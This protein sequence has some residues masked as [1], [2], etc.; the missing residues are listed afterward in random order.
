MV[1]EAG[2]RDEVRE[3]QAD[4]SAVLGFQKG[5]QRSSKACG[6]VHISGKQA[7][8]SSQ[9]GPLLGGGSVWTL[10]A[11]VMDFRV[12]HWRPAP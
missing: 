4:C 6:Q 12:Q 10:S 5:Y 8:I 3:A 9:A 2:E 7:Y 11:G 1:S